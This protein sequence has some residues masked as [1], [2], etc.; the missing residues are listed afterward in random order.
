MRL[1]LLL[2]LIV[3][4]PGLWAAPD[5]QVVLSRLEGYEWQLS[6]EDFENLP[7]DTY[8]TLI[9]IVDD[10][11][12]LPYTLGRA[13]SALSLYKNDIV[14]GFLLQIIQNAD[15]EIEGLKGRKLIGEKRQALDVTCE[16]FVSVKPKQLKSLLLPMLENEDPHYRVSTARCLGRLQLLKVDA[17]IA[18]ALQAYLKGSRQKWERQAAIRLKENR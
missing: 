15:I 18:S 10:E 12:L 5:K 9:D 4:T 3:T 13:V 2:A 16:A 11:R 17:E 8:L 14:W 7:A 6:V 1:V